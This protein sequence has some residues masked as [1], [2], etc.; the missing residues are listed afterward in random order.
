MGTIAV[1]FTLSDGSAVTSVSS[2]GNK[3]TLV[4][5]VIDVSATY[6]L[7][8]HNETDCITW[9]ATSCSADNKT[10]TI[11]DTIDATFAD[12]AVLAINLYNWSDWVMTPSISF[13]L[14][15]GPTPVIPSSPVP[16]PA[17]LAL[18]GTALGGIGLIRRRRH[19]AK[20][21]REMV[22]AT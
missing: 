3:A 17:S 12:G 5:G 21:A 22:S 10:T 20:Q 2:T 16:E 19:D 1:G 13:D 11:G 9:S 7:F 8:Y 14:L 18:L 4:G 15:N 6:E